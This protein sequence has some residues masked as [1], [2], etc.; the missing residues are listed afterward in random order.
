MCSESFSGV[1][2]V[3]HASEVNVLFNEHFLWLLLHTLFTPDIHHHFL[4]SNSETGVTCR[5]ASAG[6]HAVVGQLPL[7]ASLFS[8][9]GPGEQLAHTSDHAP[10]HPRAVVT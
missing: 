1:C 4:E 6:P 7:M 9:T 5:H 3:V 2:C 10:D 8:H